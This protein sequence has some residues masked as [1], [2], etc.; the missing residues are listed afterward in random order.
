VAPAAPT[1]LTAR[2]AAA[3]AAREGLGLFEPHHVTAFRL[4]HGHTEGEP[5]LAA[6]VYARTLVL[7]SRAEPPAAGDALVAQAVAFYRE[8]L[9]WLRVGLVKQRK[10]TDEAAR[11]GKLLFGTADLLDRKVKEGPVSY[12]LDLQLNHDASLYLDTRT[13]RKWAFDTLKDQRVLNTFAYTGSLGVAAAK[14]GASRVVQLDLSRPFLN[15]AKVS[16]AVNNLPVVKKDFLPLDFFEGV[17]VLKREGALFDCVFVDPPL[18]STT[19]KGVVDLQTGLDKLVNK[20]RPLV[21]DGGRLVVIDNALFLSGA[22]F[23]AK[24]TALGE[25][26]FLELETRIDVPQDFSGT[27]ATRVTAWPADPAPFGHPTK[28]AVLR[29]KRKDGKK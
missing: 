20:V 2:L 1:A 13:L 23:E 12:A 6:D 19:E 22:E 24:L 26:G 21:A 17:G 14:G 8:K 10:S 18:H 15:V 11:S 4:F 5:L 7:H 3:L 9:P 25:G 29:A 16:M 28:I 27:A